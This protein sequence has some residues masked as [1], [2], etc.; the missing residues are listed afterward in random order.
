MITNQKRIGCA[1]KQFQTNIYCCKENKAKIWIHISHFAACISYSY[2]FHCICYYLNSLVLSI[3]WT[4]ENPTK[5]TY[6]IQKQFDNRHAHTS[7]AAF[8]THTHTHWYCTFWLY[9]FIVTVARC[10][11]VLV[12]RYIASFPF[13]SN[14]LFSFRKFNSP[15]LSICI[16]LS[17]RLALNMCSEF[18]E[19]KKKKSTNNNGNNNINNSGN[20]S[21]SNSQQSYH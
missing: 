19:R 10:H 6:Q 13:L 11:T 2:G 18:T 7:A 17:S 21:S 15:S 16:S 1:R 9:S 12:F 3:F 14:S 5:R 20:G 8:T 4:F